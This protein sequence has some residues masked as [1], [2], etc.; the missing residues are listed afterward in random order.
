MKR[1]GKKLSKTIIHQLY[2]KFTARECLSL[3][4]KMFLKNI[5]FIVLTVALLC[6]MIIVLPSFFVFSKYT[7][8]D[9]RMNIQKQYQSHLLPVTEYVETAYFKEAYIIKY[10]SFP[11]YERVTSS[12]IEAVESV[13][14]GLL[15]VYGSYYYQKN[16]QDFFDYRVVINRFYMEKPYDATSFSEVI[17]VDDFSTFHEPIRYGRVP[18]ESN[19]VMIY[20]YMAYNLIQV[21]AFSDVD[22]IEGIL[23][24]TLTD[25]DTGNTFKIVGILQSAYDQA[26]IAN[27][28]SVEYGGREFLSFE[29]S[30]LGS[31][32]SIV[33]L[34]GFLDII[35][36]ENQ[37]YS[38]NNIEFRHFFQ[39]TITD[40]ST[41]FRKMVFVTDPTEF[42]F[43]LDRSEYTTSGLLLSKHQLAHMMGV[44]VNEIT[45]DYVDQLT[46]SVN[47]R[48]FNND[49]M[50]GKMGTAGKS[51]VIYGV[52]ESDHL[53]EHQVLFLKSPN[54]GYFEP[55]GT[56]RKMY[57]SMTDD[58]DMNKRVFQAF[59]WPQKPLSYFMANPTHLEYGFAETA[60][61]SF[62]N[63]NINKYLAP[64]KTDLADWSL[65]IGLATLA[66]II[67]LSFQSIQT[68]KE[69]YSKRGV[70]KPLSLRNKE[71]FIAVGMQMLLLFAFAWSVSTLPSKLLLENQVSSNFMGALYGIPFFAL[72]PEN[73]AMGHLIVLGIGLS[74]VIIPFLVLAID[75]SI[76]VLKESKTNLWNR[77]RVF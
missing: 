70:I 6:A 61:S 45:Y 14:H 23:E 39:G 2:G 38:V 33:A 66:S 71:I 20:D 54:V 7:I 12:D 57:V 67:V 29:R 49:P 76:R 47:V 77:L 52:Y 51:I 15:P 62:L 9:A 50:R 41:D 58:W 25:K 24:R 40:L 73:H 37:Y 56:M 69:D 22:E 64:V 68:I 53:D 46:F 21:G 8:D 60:P 28:N 75:S 19:E 44:D 10:G 18:T 11:T 42:D 13:F 74:G 65:I 48:N 5:V 55:N 3:M 31:L 36:S 16:F 17:I 1:D 59:E 35:E 30:Y 72:T 26:Y 63:R 4:K 27:I 34:P 43:I 32:Q